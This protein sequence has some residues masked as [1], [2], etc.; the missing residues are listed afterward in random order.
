MGHDVTGISLS[1]KQIEMAKD[2]ASKSGAQ[3]RFL[4]MDG[5]QLSF[6]GEDGTFDCVWISEVS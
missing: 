4:Q 6:P 5:E 1:D 2:N 3:V